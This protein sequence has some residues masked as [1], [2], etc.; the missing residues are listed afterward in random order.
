MNYPILLFDADNTLFDFD[1]AER[2]AFETLCREAGLPFS[3]ERYACYQACNAALWRDFD[4]GLCDKEFLR[5][6]R[7]RRYLRETGAAGDAAALNRIYSEALG[8]CAM[9][10]PGALD[11]CRALAAGGRRLFLITNGVAAVQRARF[12]ASPLAPCFEALFIS[13]AVGCGKPNRAYFDYVLARIP[14]AKREDCLVIGDSLTSDIQGA[15]NASLPC[16][17]F[18]PRGLPRPA[19]PR[20]DYEIR[21]LPELAALLG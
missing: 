14:G 7:F 2:T 8:R 18:N 13:E 21:A 12:A 17:W 5:L 1:A 3:A 10:L 19:A 9:L 16:C 6:E 4:R 11:L 15:N 20:I